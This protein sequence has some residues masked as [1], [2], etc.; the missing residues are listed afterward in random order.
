MAQEYP[1][2]LRLAEIGIHDGSGSY[3]PRGSE[4][5]SWWEKSGRVSSDDPVIGD[6]ESVARDFPTALDAVTTTPLSAGSSHHPHSHSIVPGG[7]LV[8][9]YTTRFTPFTSLMIRVAT[10]PMNFMSKG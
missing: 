8:T 1:S 10:L 9:S 3:L 2:R 4:G 5:T 6:C 7:L